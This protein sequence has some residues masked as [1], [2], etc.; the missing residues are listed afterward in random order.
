[1]PNNDL[2]CPKCKRIHHPAD[3][4]FALFMYSDE[5]F[6]LEKDRELSLLRRQV[7]L[8]L[9]EIDDLK[10]QN[11]ILTKKFIPDGFL[12][13]QEL[14]DEL[15]ESYKTKIDRLERELAYAARKL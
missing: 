15:I 8:D 7:D 1:M 5:Q 6:C 11:A 13:K 12:D 10:K 2:M 14:T 3:S 9:A 4:C